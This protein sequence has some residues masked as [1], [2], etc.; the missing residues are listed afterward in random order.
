MKRKSPLHPRGTK[1]PRRSNDPYSTYTSG[2]VQATSDRGCRLLADPAV[3]LSCSA[4]WSGKPCAKVIEAGAQHR[5]RPNGLGR[6][7]PVCMECVY[8]ESRDEGPDLGG[9]G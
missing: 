4:I 5:Y 3:R 7:L 2:D 1:K 9:G 6:F 8:R